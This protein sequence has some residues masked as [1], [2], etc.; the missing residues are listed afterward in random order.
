MDFLEPDISAVILAGG[1]SRRMGFDKSL[2]ELDGQT[3]LARVIGQMQDLFAHVAV[4]AGSADRYQNL[5][6][7]QIPDILPGRGAL[8]G[9][10]AGLAAAPTSRIFALACDTPFPR[11]ELI[12]YL[13]GLS[14]EADWVVPRTEKGLEPLFAV[15]GRACLPAMEQLVRRNEFRIRLLADAVVTRYVDE[16]TLRRFDPDLRSF[17]N[18]NTVQ[19]LERLM[20]AW[21]RE[22]STN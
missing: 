20:P 11:P 2:I 4:A 6:V 3:L 21:K 1:R 15:Y 13:V 5:T 17:V 16:A 9:L 14:R 19:E 18:L 7:P 8:V 10:H 22:Q 12:H